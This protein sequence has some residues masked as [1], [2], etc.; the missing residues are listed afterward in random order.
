MTDEATTRAPSSGA[1]GNAEPALSGS[2]FVF[3]GSDGVGKTTLLN[4]V[5]RT[6]LAGAERAVSSFAF[7]GREPGTLGHHVYALHHNP[8][9]L[10]VA[11][12]SLTSLQLLHVA[13]HLD[14]IDSLV[15]PSVARGDI[16]LLDRSWW[17]TWVYG[18]TGGAER[19]TL[20]AMIALERLHWGDLKPAAVFLVQRPAAQL[21]EEQRGAFLARS[22][23]Y[24][25]LAREET[26]ATRVILVNNDRTIE[27]AVAIVHHAILQHIKPDNGT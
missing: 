4:E 9:R 21:P 22:L 16:V 2:L 19:T 26:P 7:P 8:A 24:S 18:V 1:A 5:R 11:S 20:S 13:A 25:R 15:R 27:E 6:L 23:E 3:E 17:S 12:I 10:G 14:A